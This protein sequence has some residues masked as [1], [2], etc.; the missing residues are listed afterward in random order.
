MLNVSNRCGFIGLGSQGGPMARRM[1]EAGLNV[2]LWARKPEALAPFRRTTAEFATTPA[3]LAAQVEHVGVCV[4]NDAD[5][6]EVCSQLI[7]AMRAG[8]RIAIHSTVHPNTCR[9]LATQ[10]AARGVALIDAPVSGGGPAAEAGT[11]TVMVGGDFKAFE[12]ARSI[13]S[14]FGRLIVHLG[15]IGAGQIAKLV[16]NTLMAANLALAHSAL[17]AAGTLGLE[18]AAVVQLLSASSGRSFALD[19]CARMSSP[20]TF[21]HGAS[22]LAKDVQLLG[23]VM[24]PAS[25]PFEALRDAA[26]PFLKLALAESA[27]CA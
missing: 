27:Q 11:L 7:P 24:G 6:Q 4:V 13:F 26:V 16:N 15:E 12:A 21:A 5:V 17:Q 8:A 18:R 1:I 9:A 3:E 25:V 20:H 23:N 10:A 14:T 19:V 2:T 22:L